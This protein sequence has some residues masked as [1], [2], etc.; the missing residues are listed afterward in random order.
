MVNFTELQLDALRELAN[1]GS[2]RASTA[3]AAMLGRSVDINVPNAAV[4]PVAEAVATAGEPD[5]VRHA[6][7]LG[8]EG[9]MEGIVLLLFPPQDAARLCEFFGLA[10]G[11]PDAD[12]MLGEIGNILGTNYINVLGEMLGLDMEPT[13][14]Q[15]REDMLGPILQT[16]L[17]G[18]SQDI[19][20]ALVLDSQLQVADEQCSLSFLL[21]P[22]SASIALAL[23]RLGL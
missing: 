18:V 12:S 16:V 14:P 23:E 4:L 9:D 8:V 3:L 15:I 2:G 7:L 20:A 5:A 22:T 19:D 17:L 10:P 6:V 11:T 1:I 13:P 21:L